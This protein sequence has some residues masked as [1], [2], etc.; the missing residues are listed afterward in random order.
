MDWIIGLK[1]MFSGSYFLWWTFNFG[2]FKKFRMDLIPI[3][4]KNGTS[5]LVSAWFLK[6]KFKFQFQ[7][8]WFEIN[9]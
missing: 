9:N 5:N 6:R 7:V 3:L 8:N 4:P 1:E 2:S